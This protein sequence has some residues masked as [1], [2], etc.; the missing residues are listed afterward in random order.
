MGLMWRLEER[1]RITGT[2][3]EVVAALEAM[4]ETAEV[5]K[6]RMRRM[7][8]GGKTDRAASWEPAADKI[9]DTNKTLRIIRNLCY[10]RS[11]R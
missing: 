5:M 1:F 11:D 2:N 4:A 8:T 6:Q 10:Q 7:T 9:I 3:I